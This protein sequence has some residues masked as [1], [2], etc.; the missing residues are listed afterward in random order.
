MIRTRVRKVGVAIGGGFLV[1]AGIAGL[2]LPVVPG[3]ALLAS[4]LL[5]WSKEFKWAAQLLEPARRWITSHI[6]KLRDR[7]WLRL[8]LRISSTETQR[9][10]RHTEPARRWITSH[11]TKLRDRRWLRLR[12]RI[13]S[14]ETQRDN[15]HT[16]PARRWITSHI[17]KLRGRTRGLSGRR[18]FTRQETPRSWPHSTR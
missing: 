1:V 17:R 7:R 11:V 16:E 12:L 10:N 15:R 18:G 5:L 4:G 2:V 6:T 9:D 3:T 8:R 14:T 13:S